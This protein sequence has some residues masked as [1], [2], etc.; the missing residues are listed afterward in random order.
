[1]N[2]KRNRSRSGAS[3]ECPEC[4]KK[5]RGEKGLAA[6]RKA[7]HGVAP[8][9]TCRECG[10]HDRSACWDEATDTTCWWVEEDLCSACSG[11]QP[12]ATRDDPV[13]LIEAGY[14]GD[15]ALFGPQAGEL[16]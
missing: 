15:E 8:F 6:H 12:G 14:E 9:R 2:A 13:D 11:D 4:R 16:R 10:C 7:E 5:L 3:T 1:M